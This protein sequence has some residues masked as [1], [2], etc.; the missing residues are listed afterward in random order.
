MTITTDFTTF[1]KTYH[2]QTNYKHKVGGKIKLNNATEN[3]PLAFGDGF[4]TWVEDKDG[5]IVF[6]PYFIEYDVSRSWHNLRGNQRYRHWSKTDQSK[7]MRTIYE[8]SQACIDY[9]L[10]RGYTEERYWQLYDTPTYSQCCM[11]S[12]VFLRKNRGKG[13]RMVIGDMGFEKRPNG[14]VKWLWCRD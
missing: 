8:R 10:E 4:H 11:N 9:I 1:A 6:D 5:K 14:K 12:L 7:Q 13:Y 3:I 2:K